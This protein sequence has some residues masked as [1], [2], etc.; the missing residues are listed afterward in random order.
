MGEICLQAH[1]TCVAFLR[2]IFFVEREQDVV[3]GVCIFDHR[4]V[5]GG[6][7]DI[8]D[9][10]YCATQPLRLLSSPAQAD[11]AKTRHFFCRLEQE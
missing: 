7:A 10:Y 8:D 9:F 5:L 11:L 4:L 2:L 3:Q 6:L 1:T